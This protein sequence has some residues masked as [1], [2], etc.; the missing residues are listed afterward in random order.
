MMSTVA[1]RLLDI[2]GG[3]PYHAIG[4]V[5][6]SGPWYDFTMGEIDSKLLDTHLRGE[7]VIGSYPVLSGDV[8]RW[9]GWDVDASD[10]KVAR[11]LAEKIIS[12]I[13]HLPFVVEF[14]GGKGYHIFLFLDVPMPAAKAKEIS[15]FIREKHKLP[16]SGDPHVECYPKQSKISVI[17]DENKRRV[18]N[19]LKVPLGTH[20]TSH[21]KS[22]FVDPF[23]G[24][25]SGPLKPEEVLMYRCKSEEVLELRE[26]SQN[27]MNLMAK[28]VASEW[29]EGKRHEVAL[30]LS[31]YLA[32]IGWTYNRVEELIKLVC[33]LR[34]DDEVSNRMQ[35]VKDTFKNFARGNKVAGFQSLSDA[36][37]GATMKILIDL[38][39][40]VANPEMHRRID[41]IRYDKG[42]LWEKERRIRH[43]AWSWLTDPE[44]GGRILKVNQGGNPP[45]YRA[46]WFSE[47]D[48]VAIPMDSRNF[49]YVMHTE[50]GLNVSESMV[51]KIL[52][53]LIRQSEIRGEEVQVYNTSVWKDRRLFV[54][55]GGNEV[56]I[57]NGEDPP[58]QVRNGQDGV[59]FIAKNQDDVSPDFDNPLDVWDTLI[60]SMNFVKSEHS[61]MEPD[62]QKEM[63]KAWI[64]AYFFRE[65]LPTRPILALLGAPGSGKTT[66]IRQI[67]RLLGGLR[68]DV[69][70]VIEDKP[71][72][73]RAVI[74]Q[75]SFF[76]LD[77][78]EETK[79]TW[80]VSSLDQIA[81]RSAIEFRRLY[82]T[83]QLY[84]IEADAFVAVTAVSMPF[85]KETLFQ[86]MLT[87]T[88]DKLETFKP[89]H[90]FEQYLKANYGRLW[91]DLLLK[92]NK[93][94][95]VL[96]KD[97]DPEFIVP[98]RMAD[99]ALFCKRLEECDILETEKLR[100]ALYYLGDAQQAALAESEHS[101]YP[102]LL[103]WLEREP[104]SAVG[105]FTSAEIYQKV[106]EIAKTTGH[107]MYWNSA[108][109]LSR[110]LVAM[111]GFLKQSV[112]ME[113]V[114]ED[115]P[116]KGRKRWY[117]S[118]PMAK[119]L[120]EKQEVTSQNGLTKVH[121]IRSGNSGVEH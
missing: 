120:A 63:F 100:T 83:N 107:K 41:Q 111:Q 84:R 92:L 24:W 96:N 74:E 5:G 16:R 58:K 81:T 17:E 9:L 35:A 34:G 38:A 98:I 50:F 46:Y 70:E 106:G 72:F 97:Y 36:L 57:L 103:W 112:G 86:R 89:N 49:E 64:V 116:A 23:N 79:A 43:I 51:R 73:F 108:R 75:H 82:T 67:L 110:H 48:A 39:P 32:H 52:E 11:R 104:G 18:G 31:G 30:Y 10:L 3:N 47:K 66:A 21:N 56:F 114:Q 85:S 95:A 29:D 87:L 118:F 27:V 62:M 90:M 60:N 42:P 91:A 55:T 33:E 19:L 101:V 7:M 28:A 109:K 80:L 25:E 13:S 14:S 102:L 117:F 76:V 1:D 37:S 94:V 59:Y 121:T 26:D 22:V 105:K 2:F 71:D 65:M 113:A 4:K 68:E 53:D 99:F 115:D 15:E 6:E 8:V 40:L 61:P 12:S 54:H 77:N 45:S 44:K 78:M 119:E 88:M 69:L 93:A 20:L